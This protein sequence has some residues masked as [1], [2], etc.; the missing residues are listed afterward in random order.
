M[1][2]VFLEEIQF[3]P[4]QPL[5]ANLLVP[6]AECSGVQFE[7]QELQ[8][9]AEEPTDQD[10][11]MPLSTNRSTRN[12][13]LP[14]QICFGR[15]QTAQ[16]QSAVQYVNPHVDYTHST[17]KGPWRKILTAILCAALMTVASLVFVIGAEVLIK[18]LHVFFLDPACFRAVLL[19]AVI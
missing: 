9:D 1:L 19:A 3:P 18:A 5:S 16:R 4:Q 10:L 2:G 12:E 13:M 11:L 14:V 6:Q 8:A 17:S 7:L 15:S